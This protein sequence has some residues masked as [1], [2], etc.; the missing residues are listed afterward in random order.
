MFVVSVSFAGPPMATL[1]QKLAC[2]VLVHMCSYFGPGNFSVWSV[3]ILLQVPL[4]RFTCLMAIRPRRVLHRGQVALH[5]PVVLQPDAPVPSFHWPSF[6]IG[7][8]VGLVISLVALIS[9]WLPSLQD[10]G[11]WIWTFPERRCNLPL[12]SARTM[13]DMIST[14]CSITSA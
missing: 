3:A 6:Y 12:S 4:I 7:I 2:H 9:F 14:D 1:Q 13:M 10:F 11:L 8:T 5:C